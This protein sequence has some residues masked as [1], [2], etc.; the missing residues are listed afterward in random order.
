M[1]S[2]FYHLSH[3]H[4]CYPYSALIIWH[5]IQTQVSVSGTEQSQCTGY[6]AAGLD[7]RANSAS[8]VRAKLLRTQQPGSMFVTHTCTGRE[9]WKAALYQPC[10][11]WILIFMI[12]EFVP[13]SS[14]QLCI[15][16]ILGPTIMAFFIIFSGPGVFWASKR[17]PVVFVDRRCRRSLVCAGLFGPGAEPNRISTRRA[18]S[19]WLVLASPLV[20]SGGLEL[21]RS[22]CCLQ[23]FCR[24]KAVCGRVFHW[25]PMVFSF[26]WGGS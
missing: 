11:A 13:C 18:A 3:G 14:G 22:R 1:S 6:H 10:F 23:C 5:V 7:F 8:F 17:I 20:S 9:A 12:C 26:F 19:M 21:Y 16:V 4:F 25:K 15:H 2:R 24:L